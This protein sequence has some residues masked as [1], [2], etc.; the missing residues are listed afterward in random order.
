[1]TTSMKHRERSE[2][3]GALVELALTLPLLVIIIAG[4]VD[5]ARVFYASVSLTNAARA[6]AQYG[7]FSLGNSG[8]A[9]TM[10]STAVNSV[11]DVKGGINATASRL[12]MCASDTGTLTATSPANTCTYTCPSSGHIVAT[13]T[14]TATKTFTT[15]MN[16]LPGVPGSINLSRSA[17]LRVAN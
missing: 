1:M 16:L 12:C 3:G 7:A 8:N 11:P 4:T 9:T 2:R 13:V 17:T 6:G 15:I 14:V 5:F 10:V